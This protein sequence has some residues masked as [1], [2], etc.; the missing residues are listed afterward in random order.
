MYT[1]NTKTLSDRALQVVIRN[2]I[3][4]FG[5]DAYDRVCSKYP[6]IVGDI[7]D[8]FNQLQNPEQYN[9][10]RVTDTSSIDLVSVDEALADDELDVSMLADAEDV[11]TEEVVEKQEVSKTESAERSIAMLKVLDQ[12]MQNN[13]RKAKVAK[14]AKKVPV[15]TP[16]SGEPKAVKA[17]RAAGAET[18]AARA[19][20]LYAASED[21]SRAT[22]IKLFVAELGMTPAG[23][24]TYHYNLSK[25]NK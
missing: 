15:E 11:E 22:M 12:M 14:V 17:P 10:P 8:M 24:S 19:A 21:K 5:D 13:N 4:Q 7:T 9:A 23:A 6:F 1:Y 20:A 2:H 25:K 16:E 3:K 18:K